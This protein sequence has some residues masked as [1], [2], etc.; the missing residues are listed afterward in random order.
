VDGAEH[1]WGEGEQEV[2]AEVGENEKWML[3]SPSK[4]RKSDQIGSLNEGGGRRGADVFIG[5]IPL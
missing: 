5:Y 2:V 3:R 4:K 1:G